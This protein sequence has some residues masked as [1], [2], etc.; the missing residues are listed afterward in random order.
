VW[1]LGG[2]EKSDLGSRFEPPNEKQRWD[3]PLILAR[4]SADG[5]AMEFDG[6]R[7]LEAVAGEPAAAPNLS[8][9][10]EPRAMAHSSDELLNEA[11]AEVMTRQ[12]EGTSKLARHVTMAELRLWKRDYMNLLD[13]ADVKRPE[14][15]K[16]SFLKYVAVKLT[17]V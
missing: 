17:E 8:T 16:A 10:A 13:L 1:C 12:K 9:I 11:V 6:G 5:A 4:R 2:E 3:R 7:V 15:A 14:D